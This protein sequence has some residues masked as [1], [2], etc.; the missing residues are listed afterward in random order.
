MI[1]VNL[2]DAGDG[3][4]KSNGTKSRR[5]ISWKDGLNGS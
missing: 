2:A 1:K 3:A 5:F 4:D